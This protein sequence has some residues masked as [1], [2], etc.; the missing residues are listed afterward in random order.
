MPGMVVDVL[1]E[2]GQRVDSG[3]PLVILESMKMQ[4][5]LRSPF[6]GQVAKVAVG[7]KSQVEKGML[8]IQVAG[9]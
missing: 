7:R 4:M 2:E 9:D 5:Q 8:L 3:E 1:V 6:S